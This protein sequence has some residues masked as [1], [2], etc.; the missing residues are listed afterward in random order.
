M[1]FIVLQCTWQNI[2]ISQWVRH[3]F[4]LQVLYTHLMPRGRCFPRI[5]LS[6]WAL[7][8][9][10]E[11]CMFLEPL[12]FTFGMSVRVFS[13]RQLSLRAPIFS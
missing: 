5:I 1:L 8:S 4:A 10:T 11:I 2:F 9:P 3:W 7:K 12:T 6:S 13:G